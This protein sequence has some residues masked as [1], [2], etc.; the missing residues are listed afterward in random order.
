[1]SPRP[2]ADQVV[3][4]T[5]ASGGL[6]GAM[7]QVCCGA[8]AQVVA[9]GRHLR[10]LDA[11]YQ[12]IQ[13]QGG[14]IQLYPLDLEGA[15]PADHQQLIE[16]VVDEYGRLDLLVHCAADF[17]GLTPM[18]HADPAALAR[19]LHVNL[20]AR[21]WLTQAALPALQAVNGTVVFALDQA[22][23]GEQA[24]WGGYG[25]AQSA[26]HALMAMLR[27]ELCSS[28][29]QIHSLCPPPMPTALRARAYGHEVAQISRPL[30]VA[31]AWLDNRYRAAQA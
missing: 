27:A 4:I 13:A 11:L 16:R 28:S 5:G 15:Q 29:V 1:M 25:L 19:A 9:S 8:G 10:R 17:P 24:Y 23:R 26:Q 3:L 31:A 12:T 2:L 7:A 18:M 20:T 6:G 22:Q 21:L 14:Q 30:E